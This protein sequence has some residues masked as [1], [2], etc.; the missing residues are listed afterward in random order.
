MD[1]SKPEIVSEDGLI[2]RALTHAF[3]GPTTLYPHSDQTR[4][5]EIKILSAFNRP[6]HGQI[7]LGTI[8]LWRTP[9]IPHKNAAPTRLELF[10]IFAAG[11]EGCIDILSSAAFR[12]MRTH[13][14]IEPGTVFLDYIHPWYPKAT[15][16][17]LYFAKPGN[18]HTIQLDEIR[19]G[20]L[21][22]RFLE[23]IPI[24]PTEHDYLLKHGADALEG[25]LLGSAVDLSDLKRNPAV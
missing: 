4:K 5:F 17:H 13:E 10:G 6:E 21:N 9:L 23:V 22:V 14:S 11:K 18:L 12:I 20:N 2:E 24:T 15:V 7:S 16:A 19:M 1:H 25:A 8:G 3:T